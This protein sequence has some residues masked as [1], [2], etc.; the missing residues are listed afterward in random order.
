MRILSLCTMALCA[1]L[2][3][4][5]SARAEPGERLGRYR[6]PP[7]VRQR[8]FERFDANG[9]GELDETERAAARAAMKARRE[10]KRREILERF[11]GDGD[12]QLN[13]EE[14]AVAKAAFKAKLA[15]RFDRNGDGTL[16]A[17][18]RRALKRAMRLRKRMRHRHGG[19][20]EGNAPTTPR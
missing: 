4:A 6:V 5:T 10:A 8:L 19:G 12:G 3:L 9:D 1:S 18:E 13:D 2:L 11:D 15:E 17:R 20:G 16:D 14:K 7:K